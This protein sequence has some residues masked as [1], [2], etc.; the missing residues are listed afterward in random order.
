MATAALGLRSAGFPQKLLPSVGGKWIVAGRF[1]YANN[2]ACPGLVRLNADGST[3]TAFEPPSLGL[4]IA[5]LVTQGDGALLAVGGGPAVARRLLPNG[6][7]DPSF[8]FNAGTGF[9]SLLNDNIRV[10]PDGRI[11]AAGWISGYNGELLDT[12]VV[13]LLPDGRRDP[14]MNLQFRPSGNIYALEAAANGAFAF[15]GSISQNY[16][17]SRSLVWLNPLGEWLYPQGSDQGPG[18]VYRLGTDASGRLLVGGGFQ[19]VGGQPR[20]GFARLNADGSVADAGADPA[21]LSLGRFSGLAAQSD[22]KV[23]LVGSQGS[24]NGIRVGPLFRLRA[25]DSLD[26][27]F[28]AADV[29]G[30]AVPSMQYTDDGRLLLC[31]AYGARNGVPFNGLIMLKPEALPPLPR[32]TRQPTSLDAGVGELVTLS[33]DAIGEALA[34]RWY[35]DGQARSLGATLVLPNLQPPDFGRYS[36]EVS[37][38]GGFVMSQ[39]VMLGISGVAG[40]RYRLLD[41]FNPLVVGNEWIYSRTGDTPERTHRRTAVVGLDRSIT[42]YTGGATAHPAV[43]RVAAF[44]GAYGVASAGSFAPSSEWTDY[45]TSHGDRLGIGGSDSA[46]PLAQRFDGSFQLPA[47]MAVG[48]S[49][50]LVSDSYSNGVWTGSQTAAYSLFAIE[51]VTTP[52][53]VFSDCLCLRVRLVEDALWQYEITW[54]ALGVGMV[55]SYNCRAFGPAKEEELVSF[56]GAAG[57]AAHDHHPAGQPV[58]R[59][60]YERRP[61]GRRHRSIPG[62]VSV[63]PCRPPCSRRHLRH[64]H[65]PRLHAGRCRDLRRLRDGLGQH[66]LQ[67]RRRWCP[68]ARG[69][70]NRRCRHDPGGVARHRPSE[71]QR[72]RPVPARR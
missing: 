12:G 69:I 53:G 16:G 51:S 24:I 10:L 13:V 71:G 41:Y 28:M 48:E 5:T 3:D 9:G 37:G 34:Y 14:S 6:Q 21:R 57:H 42:S 68:A 8:L 66:P 1:A 47:T 70:A 67:T 23:L 17:S 65:F 43:L 29:T 58:R 19:S 18:S 22:N 39:S 56:H 63:V 50:I 64:A 4:S 27:A 36:V 46:G 72:L 2:V 45:Y 60:R 20:L 7:N 15:S 44:S 62:D 59:Q 33:V 40:P 26:T 55:K 61:N 35:K 30:S 25:D 38:P 52:A 11:V 49:A 31:G 54:W 32:I